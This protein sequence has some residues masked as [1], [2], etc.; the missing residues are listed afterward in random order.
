MIVKITLKYTSLG[1]GSVYQYP[2]ERVFLDVKKISFSPRF[3]VVKLESGATHSFPI[4]EI[5]EIT[6]KEGSASRGPE[7]KV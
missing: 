2:L 1:L 6:R 3:V 5:L 7:I 4:N